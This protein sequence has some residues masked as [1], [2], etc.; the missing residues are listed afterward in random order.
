MPEGPRVRVTATDLDTGKENSIDLDPD[1]YV[2]VTGKN[3]YED[4]RT[5]HGNGTIVLVIKR[6][7]TA[8][9]SKLSPVRKR[10]LLNVR[11]GKDLFATFEGP[12]LGGAIRSI[13]TWP[14]RVEL[15]AWD[16][17]YECWKLTDKGAKALE[18]TL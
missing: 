5:F 8:D 9:L 1:G 14:E 10:V 16:P 15:M 2:I 11:Q 7:T 12:R 6:K 13:N 3:M 4:G 17:K 18:G